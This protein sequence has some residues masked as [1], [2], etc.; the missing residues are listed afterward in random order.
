MTSRTILFFCAANTCRSPL[1]EV[2]A[3][4]GCA[5]DPGL[6]FVSAGLYAAE[7]APASPGSC[8]EALAR[9]LDLSRHGSRHL[10]EE[11]LREADWVIGMTA[12]QVVAF[13]ERHPGFAGRVG[14]LGQPGVDLSRGGEPAAGE[15]V[16]DPYLGGPGAH[17][18]MAVQIERLLEGWL[19]HFREERT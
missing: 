4:S 11:A 1:A 5:D 3:A 6:S 8:D 9:G 13:R 12:E 10:D 18:G 2:L 7:G 16:A 15:D 19:P 14:A 17:A